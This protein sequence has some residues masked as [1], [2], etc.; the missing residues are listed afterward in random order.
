MKKIL[1]YIDRY[2]ELFIYGAGHFGLIVLDYIE[3][4]GVKEKVSAFI[5]SEGHKVG[6]AWNTPILQLSEIQNIKGGIIV[7]LSEKNQKGVTNTLDNLSIDYIV[8]SDEELEIMETESYR[9]CLRHIVPYDFVVEKRRPDITIWKKILVIKLDGIGD[10]VLAVPFLRE[11]HR[12]LPDSTITLIT[13]SISA[14]IFKNCP[15][16]DE[17]I[18]CDSR[19]YAGMPLSYVSL[20]AKN[21]IAP[22]V[23][24]HKFDVAIV[25]RYA[26]DW[27]GAGFLALFSGA[28]DRI[29]YSEC[30]DETKQ[31][32]NKGFDGLYTYVVGASQ[33]KH[34]VERNLEILKSINLKVENELLEIWEDSEAKRKVSELIRSRGIE[35]TSIVAIGLSGS[36]EHKRW[37]ISK[38]L[39]VVELLHKYNDK[40]TFV[41]CGD[42][43]N[44]K[45]L[46]E[47]NCEDKTYLINLSG[48]ISLMETISIMK[49]SCLYIG[50]DTGLMHI[51]AA[52][53]I[54]VIELN[55][56]P[57]SVDDN[58]EYGKV[59][60][61]PWRTK[62][63][64]IRPDRTN[65]EYSIKKEIDGIEVKD[66]YESA[67]TFLRENHE[68]ID[69]HNM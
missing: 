13:T 64:V 36:G 33:P 48:K 42:E 46:M 1:E 58:S 23:E 15:Y 53:Q 62:S 17:I 63:I 34:E 40:L 41:L 49:K 3:R 24:K 59:R 11:L 65:K 22:I 47:L 68:N 4:I 43:Q 54:P 61:V 6:N 44:Q 19:K 39:R 9:L 30:I 56:K 7:A 25:P 14:E 45:D 16:V 50:N 55:C 5:V 69:Y 60:F 29:T 32:V 26:T 52:C 2:D 18:T 66:V 35:K 12:D 38:Y 10:A 20:S 51:A 67:L 28:R 27:Y 37:A 57:N 8:F 21:F 31:K